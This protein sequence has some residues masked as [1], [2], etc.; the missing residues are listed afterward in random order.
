MHTHPGASEVLI[1]I[2]GKICAGFIDSANNVFF[3]TLNRGDIMV[4]PQGL[5]HFQI[6]S[7]KI[8]AIA[9]PSFSSP[10]PGL[11]ITDFAFFA[12]SLPTEIITTTTFLPK[13][14]VMKLKGVLGGTN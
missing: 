1:V 7:G 14:V 9:F 12:N 10:S 2:Q 3:K 11:Q 6:N 5:L 8:P 4:F 13:E